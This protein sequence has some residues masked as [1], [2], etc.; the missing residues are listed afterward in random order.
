MSDRIAVMSGGEALQ[1][2]SADEI[3]EHP[4]C[5]FV[6]DFI[7]E[8]NFLNGNVAAQNGQ[9]VTVLLPGGQRLCAQQE[10][11]LAGGSAVTVA[12]RPEKMNLTLNP[13]EG[14]H[15]T[16]QLNGRVESVVYIGTDTHYDVR[17]PGEQHVRVREQ[18][19]RP[20]SRPLAEEGDEVSVTFSAEA[21]RILTE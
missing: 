18:N 7:G 3:Y 5:R 9:Q 11:T 8:T 1:V 12:V 14:S 13:G 20:G 6:A 10:A 2:G 21:A 4:N 17:L 19:H 15:A 16:N